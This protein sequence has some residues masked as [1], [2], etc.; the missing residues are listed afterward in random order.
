MRNAVFLYDAL[1]LAKTDYDLDFQNS[2]Y[3]H[4]FLI[5]K[6]ALTLQICNISFYLRSSKIQITGSAIDRL[7][8]LLY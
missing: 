2:F 5:M 4:N 6:M 1:F 8:L 7:N 3:M